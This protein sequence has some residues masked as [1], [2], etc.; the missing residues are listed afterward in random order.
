MKPSSLLDPSANPHSEHHNGSSD[1]TGRGDATSQPNAERDA[2]G[3]FAKGNP[4][5]PGNPFARQVAKLRSALV[6]RVTESDMDR[7]AEDLIVKARLGDMA[8]IKLLFLYVLGKPGATVNPDTVDIEEWRQTI[9][10]LPEIM[11]EL[12]TAML[13]MPIDAMSELARI[14]QPFAIDQIGDIITKAVTKSKLRAAQ[15][16][17]NQSEPPNSDRDE[18]APDEPPCPSPNGGN[19]HKKTAGVPSPNG[20][21]GRPKPLPPWLKEIAAKMPPPSGKRGKGKRRGKKKR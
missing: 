18:P 5:G 13:T 11:H 8:A 4:G 14:C 10:P 20:G 21:G 16:D 15:R 9:R 1:P 7:I 2:K 17:G 6:N 3:R 19:G 12:P